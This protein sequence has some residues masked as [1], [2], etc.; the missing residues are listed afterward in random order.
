MTIRMVLWMLER[1]VD[2]NGTIGW[3]LRHKFSKVV[4]ADHQQAQ[5]PRDQQMCVYKTY[6][7]KDDLQGQNMKC[8]LQHQHI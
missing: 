1:A 4:L 6:A 5:G 7:C 3:L 2:H 8:G